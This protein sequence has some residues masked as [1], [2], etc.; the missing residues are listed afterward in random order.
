MLRS[1]F[2]R[3]MSYAGLLLAAL[4]IVVSGLAFWGYSFANQSVGDQLSAQNITMPTGDGLAALPPAD[5]AAL[6]P[7]AG[8]Q[9]SNG[10]QAKAYA[11]H[12][13]LV[14]MN[15]ASGGKSYAEISSACKATDPLDSPQ[16]K[17]KYNT[18]FTGNA[19]RSMLLTAYAFGTIAKIALAGAIATLVA[20]LAMLLLSLLGLSHAK[21]AGDAIVG[22]PTGSSRVA[23]SDATVGD[24]LRSDLAAAEGKLSGAVHDVQQTVTD[25][26]PKH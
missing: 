12:Y 11:D 10:D 23:G 24:K 2:D 7:Y 21:K 17:L 18:M 5:Q 4:L 6:Q 1:T 26:L 15:K 20:G 9:M 3:L 22:E 14:H 13:I 19:L 16:C 25:H 8:Q